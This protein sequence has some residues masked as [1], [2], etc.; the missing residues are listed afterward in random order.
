MS[1]ADFFQGIL[2]N[3]A[4]DLIKWVVFIAC[5]GLLARYLTKRRLSLKTLYNTVRIN[6]FSTYRERLYRV[7][8]VVKTATGN[9]EYVHKIIENRLWSK[10]T[11]SGNYFPS[12][13][14][15]FY[16]QY[17]S[18]YIVPLDTVGE[19]SSEVEI[20][21][22]DNDHNLEVIIR[23]KCGA[24]TT[25]LEAYRVANTG[26]IKK[27]TEKGIGSDS[28]DITLIPARDG[29]PCEIH[30]NSVV[31]NRAIVSET[32]QLVDKFELVKR[33][34]KQLRKGA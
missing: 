7:E 1:E 32:W 10:S 15:Y 33:N 8:H 18:G 5:G 21:D 29:R 30:A 27:L 31:G 3:A 26:G 12:N 25:V 28:A 4:W 20:S 11:D 22:I 13:E 23:Y 19:H 9:N 24:H 6:Y 17:P 16:Y 34:E 14:L 2:S